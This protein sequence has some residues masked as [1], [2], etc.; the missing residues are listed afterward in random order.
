[1]LLVFGWLEQADASLDALPQVAQECEVDL[2]APGLSKRFTAACTRF[3]Q[4]MLQRMAA[5]LMQADPVDI[6]LLRR[7]EAVV[8]EDSSVVGLPPG[9]QEGWR[10]CGG[11]TGTSPAAVTLQ[12]RWDLLCGQLQGPCLSDGRLPD[13]RSPFKALALLAGTLFLADLGYFDLAWLQRQAQAGVWWLMRL[14]SQTVLLNRKGSYRLQLRGLLPQ[15]VGQVVQYGVLGGAQARIPARLIIVRVPSEVARQ[16]RERLEEEARDKGQAVS[17]EQWYLAEWT[18]VITN[19]SR[20]RLSVIEVLQLMRIRWQ[21][22]LLYKLWKHYG[23]IDEW[24]SKQPW[25]ILCEVYGKLAAMLLHHWLIL[26]G[27]WHDPWRSLG[28]AAQV[29]RR[30]AMR[31]LAALH[32]EYRWDCLERSLRRSMRSGC[33]VNRRKADPGTMQMLLEGSDWE[34]FSP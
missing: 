15:Q 1:L 18:I 11:R 16:R 12:V 25:R 21:L 2:S 9:L 7:F 31:V 34:L 22:E 13:H 4:A 5:Q 28:K 33:R 19:V 32:G 24:R 10:G 20:G 26:L 30:L 27:C 6:P 3:M 29:V 17:P 14:K 23:Q 8:V